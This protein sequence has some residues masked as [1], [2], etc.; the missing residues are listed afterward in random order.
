MKKKL[1]TELINLAQ[2]ILRL[3]GKEDIEAMQLASQKL[4]EKLTIFMQFLRS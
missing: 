2:D 4:H 1:E 3:K